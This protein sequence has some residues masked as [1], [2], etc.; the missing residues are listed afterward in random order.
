MAVPPEDIY[1][2]AALWEVPNVERYGVVNFSAR[3]RNWQEVKEFAQ[4]VNG[5]LW[6]QRS[7]AKEHLFGI[8]NKRHPEYQ[9]DDE[10]EREL[11]H[12]SR[13]MELEEGFDRM[14]EAARHR[15]SSAP[16]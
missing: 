7:L 2:L 14:V 6:A 9:Q 16:Y 8:P 11:V 1:R 5:A 3:P 15:E 10:P 12:L 13:I 4:D